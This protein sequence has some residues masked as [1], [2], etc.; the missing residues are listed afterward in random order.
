MITPV[1]RAVTIS[2]PSKSWVFHHGSDTACYF[3]SLLNCEII[4]GGATY[5]FPD[6]Q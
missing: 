5:L 3:A 6:V 4:F 2:A 1:H